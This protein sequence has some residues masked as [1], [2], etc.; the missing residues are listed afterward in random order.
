M[1][2]AGIETTIYGKQQQ[3]IVGIAKNRHEKIL[4]QQIFT[5]TRKD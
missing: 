3:M 4:G 1:E 2:M 5:W